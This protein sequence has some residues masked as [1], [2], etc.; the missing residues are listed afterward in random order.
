V[1]ILRDFLDPGPGACELELRCDDGAD[2]G[3]P[4]ALSSA[5]LLERFA[6]EFRSLSS[7]PGFSLR[8][9]DASAARPVKTGHRR[10]ALSLRHAVEAHCVAMGLRVLVSSPLRN[11]WIVRH[12]FDGKFVLTDEL[13]VELDP[14]A[15]NYVIVGQ[16]VEPT[17]AVTFDDS[18][19]APPSGFLELTHH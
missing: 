7:E 19:P 11:P 9:L 14:P 10:Y 6:T 8:R 4:E 3:D 1:L 16:R 17:E 18:G 5:A 2:T 12:R 13:G 15:T